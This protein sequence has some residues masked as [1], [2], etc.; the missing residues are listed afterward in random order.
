VGGLLYLEA[1]TLPENAFAAGVPSP[2]MHKPEAGHWRAAEE[3]LR[4]LAG[5]ADLGLCFGG[6]DGLMACY[7]AAFS[8]DVETRRSTT[9]WLFCWSLEAVSRCSRPQPTVSTST[10]E[11]QYLAAAVATKEALW[12][13]KPFSDLGEPRKTIAIGEENEH[14]LA[15]L[16]NPE[17]TGRAK[18]NDIAHDIV[19]D[20]VEC[21]EVPFHHT[22]TAAMA[23]DGFTS[24]LPIAALLRVRSRLGV[25]RER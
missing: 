16:V 11:A 19:R 12:S 6:G 17:G 7:D 13:R 22:P 23:A 21:G 1:T 2:Y 20:R 10:A 15:M 24:P 4:Y 18:Y 3:V 25:R 5:T 14:C 9:K 8:S